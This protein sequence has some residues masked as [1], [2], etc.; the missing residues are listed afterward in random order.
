MKPKVKIYLNLFE[1]ENGD[2]GFI[3]YIE[4]GKNDFAQ[5]KSVSMQIGTDIFKQIK[6]MM[7]NYE[8]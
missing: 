6:A 1:T 5:G 2:K 7:E 3:D 8:I 4:I